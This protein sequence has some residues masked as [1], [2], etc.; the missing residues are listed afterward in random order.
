MIKMS[1]LKTIE[2]LDIKIEEYKLKELKLK[3]EIKELSEYLDIITSD[4]HTMERIKMNLN[5]LIKLLK[6]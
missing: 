6:D 5:D 3:K 4:R 2:D 1:D